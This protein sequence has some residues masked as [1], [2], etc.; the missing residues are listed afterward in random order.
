MFKYTH[1]IPE[2]MA[3]VGAKSIGVYDSK[4]NKVYSIP[5]GSLAPIQKNKLYSFGA[6]SD[7]HIPEDTAI[8]DLENAL[9]I[10]GKSDCAFT[11]IAG[12]LTNG[13]TDAQL[14]TYQEIIENHFKEYGKPVYAISGNHEATSGAL[15]FDRMTPYT[16]YPLYYSFE[17]DS[18]VFIM[19]GHYK[20]TEHPFSPDELEWLRNT[21]EK[22]KD[23]RCFVFTHMFPWGGSGNALGKYKDN[24]WN[25]ASGEGTEFENLM[26]QYTNVILF[27]GHSHF[28]FDLQELDKKA[29]YSSADGYRSIHIPSITIPRDI[30]DDS[31]SVMYA[32]S[33]G[34][35]VDVYDDCIVLNGIDFGKLN[36]D[37]G[38]R[39]SMKLLP[40]AT[41]KIDTT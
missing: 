16:G 31:L 25:T 30:I 20:W 24:W 12:D 32:E 35:I 22:N 10:I 37:T 6:L 18:D 38:E 40:I 36:S 39:E 26:K 34:Y 9:T 14:T 27:H 1:F 13:G 2:N 41:Y 17:K 23:K 33:E 21:L 28:R 29:N 8:S 19:V 3:P 15:D 4:G 5:L 11:C 7:P